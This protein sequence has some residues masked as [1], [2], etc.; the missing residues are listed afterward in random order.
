MRRSEAARYARWSAGAALL[1]ASATAGIYLQRKWVGY[2]EKQNAPAPAPVDVTRLSSGLTFSKMD[3]DRKVFTVEASKATDFK[4]KDASL[5]EDVKITIFG[6][7]GARHDTV[8]TKSCQYEKMTGTI[9]CS[10]EVQMDLQSA[11]EAERAAKS[12]TPAAEQKVH[13]ETRGVTFNRASGTALSD[14]PVSFTFPN[15]TGEAVGVQYDSEEGKVRLIRDVRMSL[16]PPKSGAGGK[17][18]AKTG[19]VDP[20]HVTAKSLDF[21]RETRLMR[22]EGPVT[23]ETAQAKLL[24]GELTLALDSAFHAEKLIAIAG[25]NGKKPELAVRR[26]EGPTNLSAETLTAYFAPEGSLT[27]LEG[28]GTVQG[29]RR[30]G[31]EQDEFSAQNATLGL[32]PRASQPKDINLSG[33]VLMKTLAENTGPT[34][35]LQT[36]A[37]RIEFSGGGREEKSKPQRAETLGAGSIEWTD[38]GPPSAAPGTAAS[39]AMTKTKLQADKLEMEFAAEGKARQ[40]VATGN[41]RTERA[42]AGSPLQTAS[43]QS[44]IAQLLATGGW[45]QMDLKGN[46]KLK[47]G[48]RSG[49]ADHAVF[50]RATQSATLTGNAFARDAA[51]ETQATKITFS[52]ITGDI[53]AEGGVRS[54]QFP[55]K[56]GTVRLAAAPANISSDEMQANSKTG[57]ALYSR[58]AR[59]WQGD[60]VLEAESIELLRDSKVLNAAGTVRA[61]FPQYAAQPAGQ[62]LAAPRPGKKPVLWH[63]T[64]ATLTYSDAENRAHLEKNVV[65]Q[66]AEQKIHAAAMDLYFTGGGAANSSA[67]AKQISRAVGTGGVIVEQGV[68]R[69]IAER[70]EYTAAE[71]KFVMS[72]GNPTI[73]DASQGTTTGRQL[74]FFLADDTII[75]D[76]ENGSR[77]LTKHRVEK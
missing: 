66:S 69:A 21:A 62:A 75:V 54:T 9:V 76:S 8:H 33:N 42:V 36:N 7:T 4:D 16:E 43:A 56:S 49:Q 68:R 47:E 41:V 17:K 30:S 65:V 29:S 71:G 5:L 51:T 35:L 18:A 74:T 70:G 40:L 48:E 45:A 64:A 52:Q 22:F 23:A 2:R 73:F 55:G 1:L 67:G 34:R 14:Q 58:H 25:T 27:K 39:A 72:G 53:R 28:T 15:G 46:V 12:P 20:V 3:G 44:G 61:V 6:K 77:T 13:V 37:L 50:V 24:A 57:I 31:K 10:G 60:S 63:V 38:A 59:L 32:W 19:P 26:P 11:A